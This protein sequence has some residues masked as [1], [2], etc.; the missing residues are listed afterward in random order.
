MGNTPVY[1]FP[2]FTQHKVVYNGRR[3]KVIEF[4]NDSPV[5]YHSRDDCD[6]LMWDG[7]YNGH[8]AEIH[9]NP[10]GS[11]HCELNAHVALDYD[12][13]TVRDAVK[14]L[15]KEMEIYFKDCGN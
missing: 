11:F 14:G 4:L 3:Y 8:V 1:T 6:Y 13:P 12:Y 5:E 2:D 7:L 10:D 15:A 9:R